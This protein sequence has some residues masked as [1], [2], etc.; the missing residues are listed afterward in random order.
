MEPT[1]KENILSANIWI[2]G[3]FMLMFTIINY[4]V[5]ILIGLI[6]TLQFIIMLITGK[7]NDKLLQLGASLST[8][9][10]QILKFLTFCSEDKPYPFAEWPHNSEK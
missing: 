2:R 3:I 1:W 10:Y 8:Y 5:K 7:P 6:A 9:C 4:F